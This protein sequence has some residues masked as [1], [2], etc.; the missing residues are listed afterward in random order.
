MAE[1]VIDPLGIEGTYED[2]G[3]RHDGARHLMISHGI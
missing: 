3:A 1:N 2:F